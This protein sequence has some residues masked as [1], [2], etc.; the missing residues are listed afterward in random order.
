VTQA[1]ALLHGDEV[2]PL[3]ML[4]IRV[5][6]SARKSWASFPCHQEPVPSSE[7]SLPWLGKNTAQLFTLFELHAQRFVCR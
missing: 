5:S 1:H 6:R 3:A 7:N 4:D 2:R